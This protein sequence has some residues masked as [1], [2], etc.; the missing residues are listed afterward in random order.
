M[1]LLP[2]L[3]GGAPGTALIEKEKERL[4]AEFE[5]Q[6]FELRQQCE[7]ERLTKEELQRKYDDLK[8]QYETE[9]D[10]LDHQQ[11]NYIE[12]MILLEELS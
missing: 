11:G 10:A 8:G 9:I 2:L 6:A 5:R 4:R 3:Q 1:I 7:S 12:K